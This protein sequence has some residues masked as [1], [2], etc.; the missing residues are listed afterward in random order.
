M[1]MK[2]CVKY[3]HFLRMISI[4]NISEKL[5]KKF[6]RNFPDL[7]QKSV[8]AK[9]HLNKTFSSNILVVFIV[10][11]LPKSLVVSICTCSGD[12]SVLYSSIGLG[13]RSPATSATAV[14]LA[15]LISAVQLNRI[16][17]PLTCCLADP[18]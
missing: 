2:F 5:R 16:G 4:K 6:F 12:P 1:I 7:S 8:L 18:T 3:L 14:W 13:A 15:Q 11:E 9:N 17:H 10:G